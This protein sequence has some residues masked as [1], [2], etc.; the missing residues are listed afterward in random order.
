MTFGAIADLAG[1]GLRGRLYS[2][3]SVA[4]K[5]SCG[6]TDVS[7]DRANGTEWGWLLGIQLGRRTNL[8]SFAGVD[9]RYTFALSDA[10]ENVGVY[11][12][13]WQFRLMFGKALGGR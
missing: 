3:L 4:F 12:R 8:D 10:I 1:G 7:C 13:P 9:M 2:G 5:V 6:S 11:N